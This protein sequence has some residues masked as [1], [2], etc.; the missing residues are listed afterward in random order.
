MYCIVHVKIKMHVKIKYKTVF[1]IAKLEDIYFLQP[2][3]IND[4]KV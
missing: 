3:G 4:A 1:S 2:D